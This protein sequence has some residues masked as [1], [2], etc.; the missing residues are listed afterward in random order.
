M[1][2]KA[3]CQDMPTMPVYTANQLLLYE[4]HVDG[5]PFSTRYA[6]L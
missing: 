3:A 6:I 2:L 1:L 5:N 4:I